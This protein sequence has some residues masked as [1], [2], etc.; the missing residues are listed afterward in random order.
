[1]RAR[2]LLDGLAMW[3][4]FRS[5]RDPTKTWVRYCRRVPE[6]KQAVS[7]AVDHPYCG[8]GLVAHVA[9]GSPCGGRFPYG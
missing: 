8:H 7:A 6:A 2:T 9:L 5:F 4:V 1:M 3:S